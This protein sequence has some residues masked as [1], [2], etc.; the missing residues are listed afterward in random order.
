MSVDEIM[1]NYQKGVTDRGGCGGPVL[2]T[3]FLVLLLFVLTGCK[4]IEYIPVIE[5]HTDTTYITKWQ[6]DSVW[7]HDSVFVKEATKGD[8]VFR[9]IERWHIKYVEKLKIDTLYRHKTDSI[10]VPYEVPAKLSRWER[11]KV[12]WGGYAMLLVLAGAGLLVLRI[13]RKILS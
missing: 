10:P 5:H 9:D 6:R 13:K 11:L 2:I 8:T 1:T 12:D 3:M 7:L 4:S